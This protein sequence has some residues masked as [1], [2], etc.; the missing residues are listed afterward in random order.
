[1]TLPTPKTLLFDAVGTLMYPDPPVAAAYGRVA[2][3][4]GSILGEE[5]IAARFGAALAKIT[6]PLQLQPT[7]EFT[8]RQRWQRIVAD[9]LDDIPDQVDVA[10]DELWNHFADA[11]NWALYEDVLPTLHALHKA[12]CTLGIASNFD[13]RLASIVAAMPA[14][15][16]LTHVFCSSEV[17]WSKPAPVFFQIIEQRL[18]AGPGEL[19]MIGDDVA[20]DFTAATAAGWNAVWLDRG[21]TGAR[22]GRTVHELSALPELLAE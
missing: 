1:M 21:Q 11:E 12:G 14:L 19:W 13:G 5:E 3:S 20:L 10:F 15:N 18:A 16:E 9:V 2:R 6:V 17:G 7:S 8:E 22:Q 4:R